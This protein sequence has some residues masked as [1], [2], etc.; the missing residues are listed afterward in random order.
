MTVLNIVKKDDEG[1]RLKEGSV[2]VEEEEISTPE[3]QDFITNMWETL[4]HPVS[5]D[6]AAGVGLAAPQVGKNVRIVLVRTKG[7]TETL[8]NPIWAKRS[9]LTKVDKEGC[10]SI[11][12]KW[13]KVKRHMQIAVSYSDRDG[14]KREKNLSGLEARVVQHEVDHLNGKLIAG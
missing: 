4:L 2:I 11:P 3:I 7:F 10:L 1:S 5:P 9:I 12:G 8:I 14:I 6:E 13:V